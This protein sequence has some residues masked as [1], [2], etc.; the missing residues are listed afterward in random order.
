[1]CR[2]CVVV[3]VR[4][5]GYAVQGRGERA[6]IARGENDRMYRTYVR[7]VRSYTD[8]I[9]SAAAVGKC[10]EQRGHNGADSQGHSQVV[11]L[12]VSSSGV[13]PRRGGVSVSWPTTGLKP[14]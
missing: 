7:S 14:S 8:V 4:G 9:E 13:Q 5:P 11:V 10:T 2:G 3:H 12:A 6:Q 1:M